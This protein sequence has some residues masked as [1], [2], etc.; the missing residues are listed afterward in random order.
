MIRAGELTRMLEHTRRLR[1][2]FASTAP[3]PWDGATAG[4]ELTVQ[5]GH[6]ACCLAVRHGVN[7]GAFLDP[8]R[9]ITDIGD[10]LADVALAV[11]SISTLSGSGPP[12]LPAADAAAGDSGP[13]AEDP[14][15]LL[16]L[17]IAAGQVAEAAMIAGGYRHRPAGEPPAIPE[18]AGT[19]LAAIDRLAQ[20]TGVNLVAQFEVM[21][22]DATGFLTSGTGV[23]DAERT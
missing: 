12:V 2:G 5:I 1:A 19:A 21:V 17:L 3:Q 7:A 10:E 9:P 6:L 20:L 16:I 18:A 22:A 13:V 23:Q 8:A 14:A 4:A 11:L 15:Q